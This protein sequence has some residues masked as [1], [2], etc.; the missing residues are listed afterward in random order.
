[1]KKLLSDIGTIKNEY[2][3]FREEVKRDLENENQIR[4]ELQGL[5]TAK[6]MYIQQNMVRS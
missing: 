3:R 6:V 1:M 2:N 4:E 5:M